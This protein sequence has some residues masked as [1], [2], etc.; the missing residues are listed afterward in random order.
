MNRK[1]LPFV[2]LFL[3]LLIVTAIPFVSHKQSDKEELETVVTHSGVAPLFEEVDKLEENA[4]LIARAVGTTQVENHVELDNEGLVKAFW[5]RKDVIVTKVYGPIQDVEKGSKLVI[6]EPEAV[7][8]DRKNRTIKI[9]TEGY[10]AIQNDKEYILF[11]KK[12]PDGGFYPLGG[13]Q[14]IISE[15][16]SENESNEMLAKQVKEKYK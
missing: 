1:V 13:R 9:V 12:H 16:D 3:L 2:L 7:Y 11:L 14:G 6:Y 5:S 15:D 8:M 4:D 10:K